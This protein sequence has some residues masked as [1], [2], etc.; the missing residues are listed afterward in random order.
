MRKYKV[1][2]N[3]GTYQEVLADVYDLTDCGGLV[4]GENER[5]GKSLIVCYAPGIWQL[6]REVREA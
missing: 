1:L 4:F 5:I 6:V 2:L 3:N